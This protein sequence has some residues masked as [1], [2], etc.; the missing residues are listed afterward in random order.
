MTAELRVDTPNTE[1]NSLCELIHM[2]YHRAELYKDLHDIKEKIIFLAMLPRVGSGHNVPKIR[3]IWVP[4]CSS[5]PPSLSQHFPLTSTFLW[6]RGRNKNF[7][8]TCCEKSKN[9]MGRWENPKAVS[10]HTNS[11]CARS[12]CHLLVYRPPLC[13]ILPSYTEGTF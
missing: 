4:E 8:Q 12:I 9:G 11:V 10:A 5:K 6:F 2:I 3:C 13:C 1:R 7:L